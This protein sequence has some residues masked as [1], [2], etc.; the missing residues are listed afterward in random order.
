MT[1]DQER[2]LVGIYKI[3]KQLL[4]AMEVYKTTKDKADFDKAVVARDR[5]KA[6]IDAYEKTL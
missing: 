1:E 3:S 6:G 5:L 4:E 2:I